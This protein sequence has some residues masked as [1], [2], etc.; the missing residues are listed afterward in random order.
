M[1]LK[2]Y[3]WA[4]NLALISLFVWAS[5]DLFLAFVSAKLDQ[6]PLPRLAASTAPPRS[7]RRSPGPSLRMLTMHNIFDPFGEGHIKLPEVAQGLC[8][9]AATPALHP[10]AAQGHHGRRGRLRPGHRR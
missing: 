8:A 5:V 2:R 3:F 1:F 6:R 9:S 7:R 10:V 4:I